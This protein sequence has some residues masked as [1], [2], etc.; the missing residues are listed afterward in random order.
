MGN[1]SHYTL[2]TTIILPISLL[3]MDACYTAGQPLLFSN[4]FSVLKC[5]GVQ[6]IGGLTPIPESANIQ[7]WTSP[8][9]GRE[10]E[11]PEMRVDETFGMSNTIMFNLFLLVDDLSSSS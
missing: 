11:T 3:R 2:S 9:S 7:C 5:P 6:T 10:G 4:P 8:V 1:V